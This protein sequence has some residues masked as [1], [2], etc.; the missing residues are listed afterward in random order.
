MLTTPSGPRAFRVRQSAGAREHCSKAAS[1][2]VGS[3]AKKKRGKTGKKGNRRKKGKRKEK[4]KKEEK[5]KKREKEREK[6]REK[7]NSK[8]KKRKER[9]QKSFILLPT[10][11]L[12]K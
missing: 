5:R 8:E 12:I 1:C 3:R 9:K 10:D 2:F 11:C 4:E 6:K 7:E